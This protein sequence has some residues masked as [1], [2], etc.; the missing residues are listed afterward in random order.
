[1]RLN[2]RQ[3]DAIESINRCPTELTLKIVRTTPLLGFIAVTVKLGSRKS[4]IY[5]IKFL[6]GLR[7]NINGKGANN[8]YIRWCIYFY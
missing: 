1:M 4:E 2:C 6:A 7:M 3:K 8:K 5:V